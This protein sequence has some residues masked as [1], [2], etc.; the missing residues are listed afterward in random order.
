MK[1]LF[2][3]VIP[4]L[5]AFLFNIQMA[6]ARAVAYVANFN[7]NTISV[8][9]VATDTVETP[10]QVAQVIAAEFKK[11][12]L[13]SDQI[14]ILDALDFTPVFFRKTYPAVYHYAVREIPRIWG[15]FYEALDQP[16]LYRWL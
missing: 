15:W 6:N 1:K 12:G 2:L 16:G 14:K 13:D 11:G 10:E 5:F 3:T 4:I 9:D 7:S 8:I